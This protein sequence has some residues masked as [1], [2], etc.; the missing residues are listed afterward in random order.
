MLHVNNVWVVLTSAFENPENIALRIETN[1]KG[2]IS[3]RWTRIREEK[4]ELRWIDDELIRSLNM[5]RS[6]MNET[7][8]TRR[9]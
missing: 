1:K 5:F 7:S 2:L 8:E 3:R 6:Q 4:R 9:A